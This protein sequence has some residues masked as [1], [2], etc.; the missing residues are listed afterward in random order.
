MCVCVCGYISPSLFSMILG[1]VPMALTR[2][3]IIFTF[4]LNVYLLLFLSVKE[5]DTTVPGG[6]IIIIIIIESFSQVL[7]DGLS[8]KFE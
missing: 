8:L 1:T 6:T 2:T 5:I 3:G 4:L 7:A